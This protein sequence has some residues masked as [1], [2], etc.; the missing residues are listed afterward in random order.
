MP[1]F[2]DIP[3]QMAVEPQPPAPAVVGEEEAEVVVDLEASADRGE[4]HAPAPIED[5]QGAF[6]EE[7]SMA[8]DE[9]DQGP[10][11]A[12]ADAEVVLVASEP[13]ASAPEPP[14]VESSEARADEDLW[15]EAQPEPEPRVKPPSRPP[16]PG[17][18]PNGA[19][20]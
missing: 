16:A 10:V 8:P 3:V 6:A 5:P 20:S 2:D 12:A 13:P 1:T 4:T 7:A 19:W 9:M 17:E 11:E 14:A 18:L 15:E